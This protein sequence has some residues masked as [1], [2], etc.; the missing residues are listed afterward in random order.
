M[1]NER[2]IKNL[3]AKKGMRPFIECFDR[4]MSE[5]GIDFGISVNDSLAAL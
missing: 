3:V 1:S 2:D 5:G 4:S